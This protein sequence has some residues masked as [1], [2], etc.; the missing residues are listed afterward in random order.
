VG[1]A[2]VRREAAI[3]GC[4]PLRA[5]PADK[6]AI[7]VQ[8]AFGRAGLG[9]E[10][11]HHFGGCA[12]AFAL[13]GGEPARQLGQAHAGTAQKGGQQVAQGQAAGCEQRQGLG[14]Q[15]SCHG[16]LSWGGMRWGSGCRWGLKGWA[17]GT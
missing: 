10:L 4:T 1:R 5:P 11:Q 3:V 7:Q 16:D 2:R 15:A 9:I 12:L 17:V 14:E 13:G 6:L 8:R